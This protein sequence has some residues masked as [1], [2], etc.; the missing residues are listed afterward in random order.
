MWSTGALSLAMVA[1]NSIVFAKVK[2]PKKIVVALFLEGFHKSI[3]MTIATTKRILMMM[4]KV[5]S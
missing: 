2:M 5:K 4:I 1:T 3:L